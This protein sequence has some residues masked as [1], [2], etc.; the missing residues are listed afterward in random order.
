[1]SDNGTP[2]KPSV[3]EL[4]AEIKQTRSELGET[5]QAL[6]AK[7]DV[8]ARAKDQV[9]QTKLRVKAQAVEAADKV[10]GA[11][12]A[13]TGR[14]R[15]ATAQAADQINETDPRELAATA[16]SRV[17]QSPVPVSLVFAG[18]V[19]LVGVILIVRGGRR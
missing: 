1:M 11:A 2:T 4:R 18:V 17:R 5:V 6:A 15:A 9:E 16:Q 3:A 12:V 13:A 8:K 19:A 10:R 14:V 7:A